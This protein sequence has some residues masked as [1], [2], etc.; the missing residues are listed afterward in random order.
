M[1]SSP[2]WSGVDVNDVPGSSPS[3]RRVA[4]C[5]AGNLASAKAALAAGASVN[6]MGEVCDWFSAEPPLAAAVWR[7]H[8][9]VVV[10]LLANGADPNADDA[11]A[12]GVRHSTP[13]ILQL[14]IDAG[15]DVSGGKGTRRPLLFAAIEDYREGSVRVLLTQPTLSCTMTYRTKT[16]EQY[17]QDRGSTVLVDMIG[18]EVSGAGGP[19]GWGR[20]SW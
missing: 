19:T 16:P 14:L 11:L 12:Y 3:T 8:L 1:S 6:E 9:D 18:Q 17:A 5:W 20:G 13:D 4:A 2:L 7:G 15:G 10:W